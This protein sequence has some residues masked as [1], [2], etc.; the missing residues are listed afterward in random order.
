MSEVVIRASGSFILCRHLQRI[1][2]TFWMKDLKELFELQRFVLRWCKKDGIL[3]QRMEQFC[4]LP[5]LSYFMPRGCSQDLDKPITEW[6]T[7]MGLEFISYS[8]FLPELWSQVGRSS[9]LSSTEIIF[10]F[11]YL[12]WA[13]ILSLKCSSFSHPQS[14]ST[15]SSCLGICHICQYRVRISLVSYHYFKWLFKSLALWFCICKWWQSGCF[16]SPFPPGKVKTCVA[17]LLDYQIIPFI[18]I[19]TE[20]ALK[21]TLGRSQR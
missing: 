17:L 21:C 16:S 12:K 13:Y 1:I 3:S 19:F 9:L 20:L 5:F 2:A 18:V 4:R 10:V 11:C 7:N 6:G 15:H 14:N 8:S